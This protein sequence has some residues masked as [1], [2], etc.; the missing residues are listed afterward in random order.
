MIQDCQNAKCTSLDGLKAKRCDDVVKWYGHYLQ[1]RRV[2]VDHQGVK[3]GCRLTLGTPKRG[4]YS[5]LMWNLAF[6]SLL[7]LI[8]LGPVNICGYAEDAGLVVSG[9]DPSRLAAHM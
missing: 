4:V 8:K 1:N 6:E 5:P 9:S 7:A 3:R 2:A